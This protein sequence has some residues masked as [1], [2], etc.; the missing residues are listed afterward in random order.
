MAASTKKK[1]DPL[2]IQS[3]SKA[4]QVLEVFDATNTRLLLSEIAQLA[5]LDLSATQRLCHTL[6]KLGYLV[7]DPVTRQYSLSIRVLDL[8]HSYK[9]SSQLVRAAMPVLQHLSRETEETVNLCVLDGTEIVYVS[10]IQ[11]RHVLSTEVITGT[12]L[13]AYCVSSGRAILSRLEEEVARDIITQ[14][15]LRQHTAYTVSDPDELM[16]H[17]RD[18]RQQGYA[19]CFEELYL[20][21]ASIAAPI[22][23]GGQ[24]VAG[25]ITIATTMARFTREDVVSKYA[26][27]IIAAARS[28]SV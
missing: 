25:A 2:M 24:S 5:S 26:N 27:L 18:A 14:S 10:R 7:K 23:G 13:P 28:I 20:G 9:H 6:N 15:D 17:V 16:Q 8:S 22:I 4:F 12:R 21:D 1:S 3:V 11:S 19:A